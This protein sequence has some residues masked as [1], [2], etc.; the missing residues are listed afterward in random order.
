MPNT[1]VR[2]A[3]E[4]MPNVNRRNLLLGAAAISTA[5]A[6]IMV[7][8]YAHAAAGSTSV[9]DAIA[10]CQSAESTY[11][12][13]NAKEVAIAEALGDKLFPEWTPPGGLTSI[14]SHRPKPFRSSAEF[15]AEIA[16]KLGQVEESWASSCMDRAGHNRWMASLASARDEGLTS[17]REQEATID[18]S[19]YHEASQLSDE[20]LERFGEVWGRLLRQPCQTIDDVRAKADCLLHSYE[21][22]G[23]AVDAEEVVAL[24]TSFSVAR[25]A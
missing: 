13:C 14:W 8:P 23:W 9:Q 12:I 4:G 16:R 25:E 17:L 19:E 11:A 5:A 24:L 10:A 15:E 7:A 3:A 2:A 1:S 22:M 20:A 21:Q 6:V 18:A